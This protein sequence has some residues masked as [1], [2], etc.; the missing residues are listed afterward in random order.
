MDTEITHLDASQARHLIEEQFSELRPASVKTLGPSLDNQAFLVN[1]HLAF[2]FPRRALGAQCLEHE[3]RAL[4]GL[5]KVLSYPI[6]TPLY[7][8]KASEDYPYSFMGYKFLSGVSA[9]D[10]ELSDTDLLRLAPQLAGALKELHGL[11]PEVIASLDLEEDLHNRFDPAIRIPIIR[12]RLQDRINEGKLTDAAPFQSFFEA[13]ASCPPPPATHVVHGDLY[14][15][16]I[17]LDAEAKNFV[18][19]IDWGDV[20]YGHAAV[21]LVVAYTMFRGESRKAFFHTYGHIPKDWEAR[22]KFK[23]FSHS[24]FTLGLA[25]ELGDD[26]LARMSRIALKNLLL[27]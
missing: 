12:K 1:E 3:T 14:G 24:L 25:D 4:G 5:S 16:H 7:V 6:P 10:V 11:A 2:K 26:D 23:G 27:P 8:G 15:R 20:H 13:F 9:S 21:D 22:A 17:L 19:L 18:T